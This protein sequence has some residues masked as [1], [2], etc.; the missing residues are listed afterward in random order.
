[1]TTILA[2][3]AD[4][5]SLKVPTAHSQAREP[6]VCSAHVSFIDLRSFYKRPG[7]F[8]REPWQVAYES[9]DTIV[10]VVDVIM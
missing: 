6:I 3:Q 7:H 8:D 4:S 10:S 5:K 1:M 9:A 2:A